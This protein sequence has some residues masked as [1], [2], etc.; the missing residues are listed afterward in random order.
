MRFFNFAGAV[1]LVVGYSCVMPSRAVAAP[2]AAG[3]FYTVPVTAFYSHSQ[4]GSKDFSA[5]FL[6]PENLDDRGTF[7]LTLDSASPPVTFLRLKKNDLPDAVKFLCGNENEVYIHNN[8]STTGPYYGTNRPRM[9]ALEFGYNRTQPPPS[10]RE[11]L[12]VDCQNKP[13]PASRFGQDMLYKRQGVSFP[14]EL[15]DNGALRCPLIQ[16]AV[17]YNFT[18]NYFQPPAN[19][20]HVSDTDT[21]VQ[22]G[23][24]L[25]DEGLTS[26][27]RIIFPLVLDEPATSTLTAS[28]TVNKASGSVAANARV[29]LPYSRI[30]DGGY[31][32]PLNKDRADVSVDEIISN[33]D[34]QLNIAVSPLLNSTGLPEVITFTVTESDVD[35][36]NRTSYPAANGAHTSVTLPSRTTVDFVCKD[37]HGE[38]VSFPIEKGKEPVRFHLSRINL[39]EREI[40]GVTRSF[41]Y[42]ETSGTRFT[43]KDLPA[44]G[45]YMILADNIYYG[46]VDVELTSH[47]EPL[48]FNRKLND[49]V[50][51]GRTLTETGAPLA[52]ALVL[53]LANADFEGDAIDDTAAVLKHIRDMEEGP[54]LDYLNTITSGVLAYQI[55]GEDGSFKFPRTLKSKVKQGP[56]GIG[57]YAYQRCGAWHYDSQQQPTPLYTDIIL[58]DL[59]VPATTLATGRVHAPKQVADPDHPG[60]LVN[61]APG[62]TYTVDIR[63]RRGWFGQG[64]DSV[65]WQYAS[66]ARRF[67]FG[68][69]FEYP[70]PVGT[71]FSLA[72]RPT[73]PDVKLSLEI[74]NTPPLAPS[75]TW[76]TTASTLRAIMPYTLHL[77]YA[78]GTPAKNLNIVSLYMTNQKQPDGTYRQPATDE[79]GEITLFADGDQVPAISVFEAFDHLPRPGGFRQPRRQNFKIQTLDMSTSVPR[80]SLTLDPEV[81]GENGQ[82]T[83]NDLNK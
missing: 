4:Q 44:P 70:V 17:E 33:N 54:A 63:D 30:Y 34:G 50:I 14:V 5:N 13:L 31:P 43:L 3:K 55:T 53:Y 21:G 61:L 76:E 60:E 56:P 12:L 83:A 72:A 65:K 23:V 51:K 47:T 52:D 58:D 37:E 48:V 79:K 73:N 26:T 82:P 22:Y 62:E 20:L 78:D 64:Y 39:D 36:F 67:E 74:W 59:R 8:W 11:L 45:R 24:K 49:G 68:M 42:K 57:V 19:S 35:V 9:A 69:P 81:W 66:A 10:A 15:L 71:T 46:P 41:D 16:E 27:T 28:V 32:S 40:D 75:E 2:E 80:L 25:Y 77:Q 38:P 18:S 6:V 7:T 29:S 1:L